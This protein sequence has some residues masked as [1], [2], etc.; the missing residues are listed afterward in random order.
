MVE[1]HFL[2]VKNKSLMEMKDEFQNYKIFTS[3]NKGALHAFFSQYKGDFALQG[4]FAERCDK[5]EDNNYIDQLPYNFDLICIEELPICLDH[6]LQIISRLLEHLKKDGIMLITVQLY[7]NQKTEFGKKMKQKT[8]W[9]GVQIR[10]CWGIDI[11][12]VFEKKG[13]YV[14]KVQGHKW[15]EPNQ[16][17]PM[18]EQIDRL[19]STHPFYFYRFNTWVLIVD[20][21][22][23]N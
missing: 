9:N 11:E 21:A 20:N 8:Y 18:G 19:I 7:E 6:P 23:Q 10:N 17:I 13:M 16:I 5:L 15:Y 12:H 14:K 2:F 3:S 4:N 22:N 1:V